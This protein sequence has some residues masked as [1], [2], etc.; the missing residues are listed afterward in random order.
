MVF[1]GAQKVYGPIFWLNESY[2]FLFNLLL[3]FLSFVL[4]VFPTLLMG[5]T[6][7]VLSRFFVRSF[8]AFRPARRRSVRD[9]YAGRGDRLRRGRLFLNPGS[10]HAHDGLRRRRHQ[11][12]HRLA[13]FVI[14]DRLRDQ[15]RTSELSPRRRRG[16][17][18][19]A[20]AAQALHVSGL[21]ASWFF[22]AVGI[23]LVGL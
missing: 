10:R 13:S 7:P 6:L 16:A 17:D 11:F 21:G 18:S 20:A 5:A 15:S 1:A 9:Q 4:L 3:F 14:V 8:A 19:A 12:S 22:R 23:R 2:P